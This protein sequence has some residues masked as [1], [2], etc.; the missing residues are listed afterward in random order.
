V[1]ETKNQIKV[2]AKSF[3]YYSLKAAKAHGLDSIDK[4]PRSLKVLL[5]NILRKGNDPE[6]SVSW[7]DAQ[8]LNNWITDKTSSHEISFYPARVL[9]QDFTGVPA[10]VDL[11]AMRDAIEVLGGDAKKINPSIPVDLVTD[12]SIQVE[13]FGSKD[14]FEKNV[15]I[16]YQRN[17]ERYNSLKW[18]QKAGKPVVSSFHT[19][20]SSYLKYYKIGFLEPLLWKYLAWFYNYC[21][22]VYVP[23]Q[24]MADILEEHSIE[25]ELKIWARGIDTQLFHPS[26]GGKEWRKKWDRE[27]SRTEHRRIYRKKYSREYSREQMK[28]PIKRLNRIMGCKINSCLKGFRNKLY[29]EDVIGYNIKELRE[30]LEKQFD[31]NMSWDNYCKYWWVDHIKPISLFNYKKPE[32][33]EFKEC[34]S[35]KNLQPMEKIENIKKRDKYPYYPS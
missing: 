10:V 34:W 24:S 19:H 4:L 26:K 22:Q 15:D 7:K 8:A 32:D 1:K 20:F 23:S 6:A 25:S 18:A 27:R 21:E 13:H 33:K 16:E 12:H 29:K 30:H 5:E 28:D 2:G 9:M 17:L 14:S 11:A 3:D 35:L 31:E